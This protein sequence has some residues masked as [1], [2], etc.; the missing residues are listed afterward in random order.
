MCIIPSFFFMASK[1]LSESRSIQGVVVQTWI[2]YFP[3]GLRLYIVQK[4]ATSYTLMGGIS[5]I[6]ATYNKG[7]TDT[8]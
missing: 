3:T 8:I 1:M 5:K 4:V 6:S 2:W 7:K